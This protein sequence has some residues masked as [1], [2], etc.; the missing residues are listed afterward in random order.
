MK[1]DVGV[2]LSA[3]DRDETLRAEHTAGG[4]GAIF[5]SEG[6][7]CDRVEK[8]SDEKL[9]YAVCTLHLTL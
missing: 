2:K 4:G 5:G 6:V 7:G 8:L 3:L 1:T 9:R